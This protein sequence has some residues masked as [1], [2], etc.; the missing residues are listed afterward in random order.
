MLELM[1][2]ISLPSVP[3][4]LFSAAG[5]PENVTAL[6]SSPDTVTVSWDAPTMVPD[7][8]EVFYQVAGGNTVTAGDTT[9]T[10]MIVTGLSAVAQ[11]SFFVVG[12]GNTNAIPSA[13]SNTA[14]VLPGECNLHVH[15]C[16][17]CAN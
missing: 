3:L 6:R 9:S 11:Y 12:F 1:I 8:Y 16:L 2:P 5:K 14:T 10:Q 17:H 15:V 4:C 7:G 13:R